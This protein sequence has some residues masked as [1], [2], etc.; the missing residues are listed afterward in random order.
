MKD[1]III[2][3]IGVI[4]CYGILV[5]TLD[6]KNY[7]EHSEKKGFYYSNSTNSRA[8]E[9]DYKSICNMVQKKYISNVVYEKFLT[10]F[11]NNFKAKSMESY[12]IEEY[13]ANNSYSHLKISAE[14]LKLTQCCLYCLGLFI[15]VLIL[16]N[17][18]YFLMKSFLHKILI[19]IFLLFVFE[20]FCSFY[21]GISFNVLTIMKQLDFF[22]LRTLITEGLFSNYFDVIKKLFSP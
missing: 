15:C 13:V 11:Y 5:L 10:S 22:N 9:S 14:I 16:P 20:A 12:Y 2:A 7:C 1:Q 21:L 8:S 19:Y 17:I 6:L 4:F 18:F 3:L